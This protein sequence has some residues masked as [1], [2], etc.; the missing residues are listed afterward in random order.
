MLEFPVFIDLVMVLD[1][2][3]EFCNPHHSQGVMS[4]SGVDGKSIK[5]SRK[6]IHF[7]PKKS[8]GEETTQFFWGR[9]VLRGKLLVLGSV[10]LIVYLYTY[11]HIDAFVEKN[12]GSQCPNPIGTANILPW[13]GT[14]PSPPIARGKKRTRNWEGSN[15]TPE[16]VEF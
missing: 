3:R 14:R 6:S 8:W 4:L 12:P 7:A 9:P 2:A 1:F 16:M 10:F 15:S 13:W 11:R 5:N